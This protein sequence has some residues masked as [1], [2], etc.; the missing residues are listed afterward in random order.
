[1]S[2]IDIRRVYIKEA[3]INNKLSEDLTYEQLRKSENMPNMSEQ[4]KDII[5]DNLEILFS[6]MDHVDNLGHINYV[7][8]S[9]SIIA[10]S[11]KNLIAPD[12]YKELINKISKY[13]DY[14]YL[15][16]QEITAA[17]IFNI[18]EEYLRDHEI[19]LEE[20]ADLIKTSMTTMTTIS[21]MNLGGSSSEDR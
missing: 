6:S 18:N 12:E 21:D 5:V 8:R 4:D 17:D 16:Q 9:L 10:D 13:K 7:Y 3:E 1:M 2:D 14:I 11:L 19:T 20:R 15:N